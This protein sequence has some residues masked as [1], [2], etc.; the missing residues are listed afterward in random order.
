MTEIQWSS[1]GV[2]GPNDGLK[3]IVRLALKR[4][5]EPFFVHSSDKLFIKLLSM[6]TLPGAR[7]ENINRR[8]SCVG[9]K[10]VSKKPQPTAAL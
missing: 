5:C 2:I 4:V 1:L 8:N 7:Q 9:S 3:F 6:N 10:M